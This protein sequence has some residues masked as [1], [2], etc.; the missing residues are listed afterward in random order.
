[1]EI[2]EG[3]TVEEN[4]QG[5]SG[6]S[7]R[8]KKV[9]K[10][11]KG[12]YGLKQ[13]GRIW[14]QEWDRH[15]VGTCGFTK[16]KNDHAVYLKKDAESDT[17]CWVLIWVDDVL[18]IGPRAMVDKGKA[19]LAKQFPV[20]DLGR[21][22]YFLGVQIVQLPRQITL[23]QATYIEKILERFN[24]ANAYTVSTPLNPGTK[25]ES[26]TG[27]RT[28][29]QDSTPEVEDSDADETEYRSMIESLM[30]LMLCT[31]PDIAFTVGALSR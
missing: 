9:C 12:L 25:L 19:M 22:H 26:L 8:K 31:R 21:A 10:L 17:Y 16:S 1:M 5:A 23:N 11:L 2:P 14:N 3:L 13:S 30:Y 29:I 28:H 6:S 15:L 24:M 7:A 27:T 4:I 18:W 20:T